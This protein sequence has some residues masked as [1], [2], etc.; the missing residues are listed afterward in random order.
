MIEF[1][2]FRW[3]TDLVTSPPVKEAATTPASLSF[4]PRACAQEPKL[5][6]ITPHHQAGWD[7]GSFSA[8]GNRG[9][10]LRGSKRCRL[11]AWIGRMHSSSKLG[12]DLQDTADLEWSVA[13]LW[14]KWELLRIQMSK[15]QECSS[16]L[17]GIQDYGKANFKKFKEHICLV[18]WPEGFLK[19]CR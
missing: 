19:G 12:S 15:S 11:S 10:W 3:G 2:G 9:L 7:L 1:N 18:S 16:C 13:N 14:R 4:F 5:A 8:S 17:T 6:R